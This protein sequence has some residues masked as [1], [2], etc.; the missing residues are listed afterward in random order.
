MHW[1][2][3][4]AVYHLSIFLQLQGSNI[5]VFLARKLLDIK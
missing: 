2:G 3:A 1:N 5:H 4:N